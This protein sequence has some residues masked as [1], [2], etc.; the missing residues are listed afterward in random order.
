M[1]EEGQVLESLDRVWTEAARGRAAV[2]KQAWG[3]QN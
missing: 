1:K 3:Q 2:S